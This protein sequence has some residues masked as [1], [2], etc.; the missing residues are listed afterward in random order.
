MPKTQKKKRLYTLR[1]VTPAQIIQN[2]TI[3]PPVSFVQPISRIYPNFTVTRTQYRL[4][5][6]F[7]RFVLNRLVSWFSNNGKVTEFVRRVRRQM[8]L[9]EDN[10]TIESKVYGMEKNNSTLLLHIKKNEIPFIHLSIHLAPKYMYNEHSSSGFVHIVK[11]IYM[12]Y[13]INPYMECLIKTVYGI[14]QPEEKPHSLYFIPY[15]RKCTREQLHSISVHPSRNKTDLIKAVD[16]YEDDIQQEMKVITTVLNKMFDE[17]DPEHYVGD[18]NALHPYHPIQ[19][20]EP[21]HPNTNA[22][23][24]NMNQRPKY[25][26]RKNMGVYFSDGGSLRRTRKIK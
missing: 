25:I 22:V 17:D 16:I 3:R 26:R 14:L 20:D 9:D 15:L 21:I 11:D 19:V 5:N 18:Y 6:I 7:D 2:N 10:V 4:S 24:R 12:N 23:L 1:M 13:D 8:G